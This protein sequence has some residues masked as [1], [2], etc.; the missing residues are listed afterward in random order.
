MQLAPIAKNQIQ[1]RFENLADNY[2]KEAKGAYFDL[3]AIC[4]ALC[5]QANGNTSIDFTYEITEMAVTG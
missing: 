3:T 5:H 1:L 4:K 2:N